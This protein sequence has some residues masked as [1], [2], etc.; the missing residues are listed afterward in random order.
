MNP[1]L[2]MGKIIAVKI[3]RCFHRVNAHH[4]VCCVCVFCAWAQKE[5]S[6]LNGIQECERKTRAPKYEHEKPVS[7]ERESK[8]AKFKAQKRE[9]KR[10]HERFRPG[11]R[12]HQRE[13]PKKSACPALATTFIISK[14]IHEKFYS[15]CDKD[16]NFKV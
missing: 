4:C 7:W 10:Q 13:G 1:I 3:M 15:I 14:L 8:S 11:V 12:K 16:Y 2:F 6:S 9:Q 5:T